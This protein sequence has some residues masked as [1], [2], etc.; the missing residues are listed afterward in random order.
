M[1]DEAS[2]SELVQ[3]LHQLRI[4]KGMTI[5]QMAEACGLPKSSLE[6]YMK[7]TGAKRPGIDAL[8]AISNGTKVS[9]DW[10]VGRSDKPSQA[11]FS[12]EDYAVFCHS[13]VLRLLSRILF[14][15]QSHPGSIDAANLKIM[16]MDF[17]DLAAL[18]V[19][20]FMSVVKVQSNHPSRSQDYFHRR[21]DTLARSAQESTG[22]TTIEGLTNWQPE[23]K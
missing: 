2:P 10:L 19:L 13:V 15:E 6:S 17:S 4:S 5:Q 20:D 3:R 16:G 18:A 1:A 7:T 22:S 9:I 21:F 8:I 14:E 11:E 23:K 12:K